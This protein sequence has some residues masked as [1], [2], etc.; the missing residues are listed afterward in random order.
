M[1]TVHFPNLCYQVQPL[2]VPVLADLIL[3][4]LPCRHQGNSAVLCGTKR[5]PQHSVLLLCSPNVSLALCYTVNALASI[6]FIFLLP[7]LGLKWQLLLTNSA[8]GT[9]DGFLLLLLCIPLQSK[10]VQQNCC[11][12]P[13]LVKDILGKVFYNP[14]ERHRKPWDATLYCKPYHQQGLP[15][16]SSSPG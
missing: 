6:H 13:P 15:A 10:E 1:L 12:C 16:A 2:T 4:G 8:L 9:G 11:V 5:L 14:R 3:P 7:L